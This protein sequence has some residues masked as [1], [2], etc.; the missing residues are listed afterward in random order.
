VHTR[1]NELGF[2]IDDSDEDHTDIIEAL[3]KVRFIKVEEEVI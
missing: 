3:E 1:L 2:K